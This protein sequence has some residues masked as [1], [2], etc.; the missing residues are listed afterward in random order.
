[1]QCCALQF[2]QL[3][4]AADTKVAL[5]RQAA[6]RHNACS[7]AEHAMWCAVGVANLAVGLWHCT[8]TCTHDNLALQGAT[9]TLLT[10]S[11]AECRSRA[12][13]SSARA[14][15]GTGHRASCALQSFDMINSMEAKA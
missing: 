12:A 13:A 1:V 15:V 5:N 6:V 9:A 14:P 11:A 7:R 8:V 10:C 2:P 3:L 4:I